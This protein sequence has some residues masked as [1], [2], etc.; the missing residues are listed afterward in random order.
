MTTKT[1]GTSGNRRKRLILGTQLRKAR[2]TVHFLPQEVKEQLGIESKKILDWEKERAEPSLAEL[3]SLAELYGREID[4]FLKVTPNPPIEMEFRSTV[5]TSIEQLSKDARLIIAKFD[6]LCRAALELEHI[7]GKAQPVEIPEVSRSERPA[8]L[9]KQQRQALNFGDKPARKLRECLTQRGVRIFELA[10]RSGEFSG[11]SQWHSEYGPCILING[12]DVLGR[13]NFTLAHEYCH[14][15]YRDPPTLCDIRYEPEQK[16]ARDER[17]GDIFAVEFLLPAEPVRK[18]FLRRGLTKTPSIQEVGKVARRW[19][20]SVQ[21]M[22]YRLEK[23][24]LITRGHAKQ[25]LASRPPK[26]WY[27]HPRIPTWR[28]MRGEAFVSN[29]IEAYN[30]GQISLGKLASYLDRPLR[31]TLQ[32]AQQQRKKG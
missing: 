10:L 4:Y 23:M 25:L 21:A 14:L 7:L 1:T 32:A 9:A 26:A 24:G 29:A 8:V 27:R 5:L 17:R 6:E 16:P 3:E 31:D 13:R 22:L 2:E 12:S 19:C 11:F 30:E 20:V 18:Y 15:L 28:R